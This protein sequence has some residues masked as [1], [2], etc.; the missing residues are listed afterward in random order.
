M[1]MYLMK[2]TILRVTCRMQEISAAGSREDSMAVLVTALAV[3][4]C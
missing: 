1:V 2:S 4:F 3:P